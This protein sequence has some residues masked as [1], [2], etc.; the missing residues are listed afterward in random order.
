MDSNNTTALSTSFKLECRDHPAGFVFWSAIEILTAILG[1]PANVTVLWILLRKESALSSSEVFILNLAVM[2]ALFCLNTP[3]DIFN[4]YFM[5]NPIV[6]L[7]THFVYNFNVIGG[8]LFLCCI[9]MERYMAVVHPVTYL[10]FKSLT[11]R[12]L[13]S[14]VAW[15][16]TV[17]LSIYLSIAT[18]EL[19]TYVVSGYMSA[20]FIVMIFCSISILRV[21]R[22]SA[23]GRDEIH[24]MKKKAFQM[25]FTILMIFLVSY[26]PAIAMFPFES[27]FNR[28]I[29][30]CYILPVCFSFFTPSSFIQPLLHLSNVGAL[31]CV[32][33]PCN[34]ACCIALSPTP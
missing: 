31:S 25:V 32:Q 8:P 15:A 30:Q 10:G 2:D 14:A 11:Y 21:L 22:R 26:F 18:F 17:A 23:P 9:C 5:D 6:Y 7:V 28:I 3:V 12:V 16:V 1:L 27:Y 20:L 4:D 34:G 19:S 29:F 33:C 13:C 24:P